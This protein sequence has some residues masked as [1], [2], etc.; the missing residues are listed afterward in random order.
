MQLYVA[1]KKYLILFFLFKLFSIVFT[2]GR[3]S[4]YKCSVCGNGNV[5]TIETSHLS[6]YWYWGFNPFKL[7]NALSIPFVPVL[8]IFTL[9]ADYTM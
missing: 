5:C 7:Q 1:N 4:Y 8:R 2:L 3:C 6:R 9:Y